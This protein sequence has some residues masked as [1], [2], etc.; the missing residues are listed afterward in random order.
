[1]IE[2][3]RE[4]LDENG[5]TDWEVVDESVLVCPHGHPIEWDGQ[6]PQGCVS[7][8]RQLGVI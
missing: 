8:L 6:C 7:A 3:A 1:M 4:L 5:Y 2:M